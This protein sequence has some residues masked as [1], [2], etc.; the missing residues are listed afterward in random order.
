MAER[1]WACV[2]GESHDSSDGRT[3]LDVNAE[4]AGVAKEE[5][6]WVCVEGGSYDSSD[7]RTQLDVRRR[8][9]SR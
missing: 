8:R 3:Q 9:K 5:R 7:G 6:S 1:S 4:V 2:E